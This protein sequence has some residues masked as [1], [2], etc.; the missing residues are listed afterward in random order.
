M[1]KIKFCGLRRK[2]DIEYVNSL[3]PD[4]AGFILSGGFKRSIDI[5]KAR[6]L[7][8]DIDKDISIVG[9]FV[10]PTLEETNLDFIDYIQL[11]GD[12]S[13][14]FCKSLSKPVI[15]VLKPKDFDK[16]DE[17]KEYV[18]YFLFDSGYG[19]GSTFDWDIIPKTDKQFF[20]AGG[21]DKDNIKLAISK[22]NPYAIDLSSSVETDGV[23]DYNK[24]K[25]VINI[26]RSLENE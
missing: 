6:E 21:L 12:E 24:M 25:Q 16:V 26:V 1:A 22:V 11:H 10:N 7:A 13:P 19:T 8:A 2:E 20:L 5:Q 3:K 18:D 9:V 17:Y 4:Y 15:K 14:A 23:K